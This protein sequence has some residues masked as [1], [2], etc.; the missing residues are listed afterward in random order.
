MIIIGELIN[1]S[2]K[3]IAEAVENKD[4]KYIQDIAKKQVEAGAHYVDV[5][6]GMRIN[7]EPEV[8]SWLV[9]TVQ[10]A[11]EGPLCIDSPN[12]K[13]L[14][15]ALQKHKGRALINSITDEK[16]RFD[17]ILPLINQFDARII[18]LCMDDEIFMPDTADQRMTIIDQLATKL[19]GAGVKEEDIFFDPLIKPISVNIN[20]GNEVFETIT[21]IRDKYANAHITCGLSNISFG[22][23]GRKDMN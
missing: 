19:T 9:E 4:A 3:A 16:E 14:A 8:L 22:L 18:A 11:V 23:P 5:N 20:F 10:E 6:A 21:R 12:H 13:A 1:T 7:D 17:H 2:R 15:K